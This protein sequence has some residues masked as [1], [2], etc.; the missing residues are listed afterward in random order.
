MTFEEWLEKSKI[1]PCGY[2]AVRC[3]WEAAKESERERIKKIVEQV[4]VQG[5]HDQ[6]F[7]CCDTIVERIK[8]ELDT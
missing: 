4:G 7:D 1:C 8:N 6:W 5:N 2:E 3:A